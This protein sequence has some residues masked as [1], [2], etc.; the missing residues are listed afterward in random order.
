MPSLRLVQN[1][2]DVFDVWCVCL[3][4]G[5][6]GFWL[7]HFNSKLPIFLTDDGITMFENLQLSKASDPISTTGSPSMYSG[8][9]IVPVKLASIT[10]L[11]P[12]ESETPP[13]T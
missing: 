12:L 7:L 2:T 6:A 9:S 3:S 13:S 5:L 8:I 4:T 1:A 11:F 10:D